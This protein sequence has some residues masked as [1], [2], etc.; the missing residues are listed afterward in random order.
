MSTTTTPTSQLPTRQQLDEIDALL[1]RMLTLPPLTGEAAPPPPTSFPA[2]PPVS[3]AIIRETT[4][5]QEPAVK[6]WRVEWPQPQTSQPPSVV[7]WGSPVPA[8]TELPPWATNIAPATPPVAAPVVAPQS[9]QQ[10][11]PTPPLA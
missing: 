3:E 2:T 5:P 11:A 1:R 8:P 6:S 10:I 4:P 9:T 7:A